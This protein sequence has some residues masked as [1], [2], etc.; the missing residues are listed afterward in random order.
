VEKYMLTNNNKKESDKYMNLYRGRTGILLR[1][2]FTFL[3]T[4]STTRKAD[5]THGNFWPKTTRLEG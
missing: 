4:G 3:H 1:K 2:I 5:M